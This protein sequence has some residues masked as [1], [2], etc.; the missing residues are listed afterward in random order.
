MEERVLNYIKHNG[1]IT[2]QQAF[3]ELG[4]S[5]LSEYIHRLRRKHDVKDEW[6]EVKTRWGDKTRVKRYFL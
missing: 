5:R 4:C 2:T 3:K 6:I 1:S